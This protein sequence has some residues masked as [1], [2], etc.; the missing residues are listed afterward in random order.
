MPVII[1]DNVQQIPVNITGATPFSLTST[2]VSTQWYRIASIF[3][4]CQQ[5]GLAIISSNGVTV[6]E[7]SFPGVFEVP[8]DLNGDLAG[9]AGSSLVLTGF[10]GGNIVGHVMAYNQVAIHQTSPPPPPPAPTVGV[11]FPSGWGPLFQGVNSSFFPLG[12]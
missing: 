9:Q 3:L 6:T 11:F 4:S 1:E 10:S 5:S 2:P 12:W 7:M 8:F